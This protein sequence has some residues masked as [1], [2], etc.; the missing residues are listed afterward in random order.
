MY[1]KLENGVTLNIG[2]SSFYAEGYN[3]QKAKHTV[4]L[5]A[6]QYL[7]N[8]KDSNENSKFIFLK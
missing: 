3:G 4:A 8:L 2:D 5:Q 6:L 1:C 7:Q